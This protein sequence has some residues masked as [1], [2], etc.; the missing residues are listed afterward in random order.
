MNRVKLVRAQ[1]ELQAPVNAVIVYRMDFI[2]KPLP[3]RTIVTENPSSVREWQI[4]T[5]YHPDRGIV[6]SAHELTGYKTNDVLY[7]EGNNINRWKSIMHDGEVYHIIYP[8]DI[9]ARVKSGAGTEELLDI[10][11]IPKTQF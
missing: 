10:Q 8:G 4:L 9:L 7:L 5:D 6:V 1:E 11:P 3:E 2:H